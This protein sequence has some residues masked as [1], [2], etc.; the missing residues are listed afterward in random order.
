MPKT[1]IVIGGDIV[2]TRSNFDM[3]MNG[4]V[5]A[6]ADNGILGLLHHSDYN[7]FNLEAPLTDTEK[8]ILKYGPCLR[9]PTKTVNGLRELHISLLTLAN[10]HILDQGEQGLIETKKILAR[11]EIN[12]VGAGN[13]LSD[14]MV[15]FVICHNGRNIGIYACAE[16]EFSIASAH[17]MGANPFDPLECFDHIMALKQ[18]CDYV[19]V[20][21][22]GGKEHYRYP[23][24]FL[25]K[26]C[27]K[28]L[29]KGADLV[30]CQHSH[31]I[32]SYER[33]DKG[34]VIYGQGNFLFDDSASDFWKTGLLILVNMEK[35]VDVQ[36]IPIIKHGS[37]VRLASEAEKQ[38]I[39][40][41]FES[42]S[43]EIL[44]GEFIQTN[45]EKYTKENIYSYLYGFSAWSTLHQKVDNR[46]F[47][48]RGIKES[49][50]Q[51]SKMRLINYLECEAHRELI[52]AGLKSQKINDYS[53]Q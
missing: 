44:N 30:I 35:T 6:L 31:C 20:L 45:Y 18:K 42:R 23:S 41:Q 10:N 36:F 17:T 53:M 27:R 50:S 48:R 47:K 22:H 29:S 14:A 4:P 15:P 19:I 9:A 49:Y 11:Y 2:P 38:D 39:M 40:N 32:G 51:H 21:Y 16:H 28:M 33:Y 37:S 25:Q 52:L 34:M 26:V 8:P 13:S 46:I 12:T 3:F 43:Q 1:R 24:P 5:T 7:I